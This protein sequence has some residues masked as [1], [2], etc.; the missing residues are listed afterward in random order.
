MRNEKW[1]CGENAISTIA[2]A[3]P[4]SLRSAALPKERARNGINWEKEIKHRKSAT[5]CKVDDPF[6]I[7]K[8]YFGYVKVVYRGLAK[9][10]NRFNMLF[11]SG[12]LL[13]VHRDRRVA[14]LCVG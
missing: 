6:L 4:A 10:F 12:N 2:R 9:N 3:N 11:A 5:R 14:E 13:T 7:V 1:W 8:R